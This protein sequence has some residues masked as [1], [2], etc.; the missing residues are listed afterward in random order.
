MPIKYISKDKNNNWKV[1]LS[2]S[3]KSTRTFR[4]QKEAVDFASSQKNTEGIIIK[5]K[6]GWENTFFVKKLPEKTLKKEPI[7]KTIAKTVAKKD[8]LPKE[9]KI[10][11]KQNTKANLSF[12]NTFEVKMDQRIKNRKFSF[13]TL[14]FSLCFIIFAIGV[15][16]ILGFF[17]KS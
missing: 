16:F 12:D 10:S 1:A 14:A 9:R 13:T 4:T 11:N 17:L 3:G 5:R 2:K 15:C 8:T 6:S 7:K